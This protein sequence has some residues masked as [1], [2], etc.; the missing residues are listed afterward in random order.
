MQR[1]VGCKPDAVQCTGGC[2]AGIDSVGSNGN[3]TNLQL[4]SVATVAAEVQSLGPLLFPA[5]KCALE[6]VSV[7]RGP[8]AG[9]GLNGCEE[10]DG[11]EADGLADDFSVGGIVPAPWVHEVATGCGSPGAVAK[12]FGKPELGKGTY[13]GSVGALEL[14]K[15]R[16]AG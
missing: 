4:V 14:T 12:T 10:F 6:P 9:P 16:W 7:V 8:A 1:K 3:C 15:H 2:T 5:L 13:A 11:I